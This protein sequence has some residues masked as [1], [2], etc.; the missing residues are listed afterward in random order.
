ME[1]ERK[2]EKAER[3]QYKN[4]NRIRTLAF[5]FALSVRGGGVIY[6][7]FCPSFEIPLKTA[8]QLSN[9]SLV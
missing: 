6:I 5:Q 2:R 1:G 9:A 3:K 8:H 4:K 7:F